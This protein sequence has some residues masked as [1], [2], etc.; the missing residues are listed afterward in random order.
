MQD[1]AIATQSHSSEVRFILN[2]PGLQI[3]IPDPLSEFIHE[4]MAAG[5]YQSPDEYIAALVTADRQ[6]VALGKLEAFLQEGLDSGPP[7]EV[8]D[9]FWRSLHDE[10]DQR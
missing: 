6:R 4:R 8:T 3:S 7:I 10:I 1:R 9:E 5:P 2:T